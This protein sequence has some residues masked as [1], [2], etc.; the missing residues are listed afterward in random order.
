MTSFAS[1]VRSIF[2]VSALAAVCA[3]AVPS[4]FAVCLQTG[5]T[6]TYQFVGQC[7]DCS[8]TGVGL[9]TVRNYTLGNALEYCNFV[10]FSYTSNLTA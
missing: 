10:S 5:P 8:G 6:T 7:T 1:K 2:R 9:L 4:G 3:V